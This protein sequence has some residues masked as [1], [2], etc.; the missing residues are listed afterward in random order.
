MSDRNDQELRRERLQLLSNLERW[1]EYPL[2]LLALIWLGLLIVELVQG[3]SP[4]ASRASQVIWIVFIAEFALRF[5]LAPSKGA[6]LRNNW[7]GLLALILPALR[8]FRVFRIVRVFR[9][10]RLIRVISS[11]NRGMQSLGRSMQRRGAQYVLGVTLFVLLG[12]AAG[13]FAFE[14]AAADGRLES[15]GEALWWTAMLLTTIGSDYWPITWEG[16]ILALL[17]SLYALAILGYIAGALATFF[18]GREAEAVDS[19]LAGHAEL[20][21]IRD[22]IALLRRA[23]SEPRS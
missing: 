18:I 6:F 23:L 10:M 22:E 14:R 2:L 5:T 15:Y 4:L 17:L 13:M 3:T 1:L 19:E 20:A 7:F 16:R 8:A 9:G 21:Q 11:I 12:G